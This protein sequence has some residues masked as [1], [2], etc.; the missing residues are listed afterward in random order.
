MSKEKD[1]EIDISYKDQKIVDVQME[2]EVK[3]SFIEYAMSVIMSRALPDVRDGLK[4]VHRRILYAMHEDHLT[5]DKPYRKSATTVGNVL[6]SYHPHGDA[7]VYDAM[8]RLA[9]PFSLR[10]TLVDGQGN[11]GN[12]DGDQ[13][14][15]YRY[16]EARMSKLAEY[17]LS[18][19]EK[20]VVDFMPNFDN[21]KEEPTVLPARYPNL[22]VNGCVG[23]AV[24]MATNVP[25][26]NMNEV[27]DGTIFLM[28]NPDATIPQIMEYIKGPDFPTGAIICGTSGIYAAYMT[29]KGKITVRG[30]ATVEEDKRR[31][32]ITEI[33]Y[34]VNKA[35]LVESMAQCVHDKKI[36]GITGLRDESGKGGLRIVVEYRRD[37]NGEVILNQLYKY[38]QLQDTCAVNMLTLVDNIPKTLN[39]KEILQYYI[40]H[41]VDVITRRTKYELEKVL[42]EMHIYE[43]YKI[44]IDNIDEVI[45]IIRASES[46]SAARDALMVRFSLSEAQAQAIVDMT[47]GKLSGMERIKIEERLL[48]LAERVTELQA[49]LADE[50][51]VHSIIK[52]ELIEIK[53]KF[54]DERR[55]ELAPAEEEI[56]I[57]D[58][59][60]RHTCVVTMSHTG[61]IKRLNSDTYQAQKRG[62]KGI[63]GMT[64]KDEDFVEHVIAVDS[65]SMLMMFTNRGKVQMLKAYRIP[66]ASRT[67]KGSNIVNILDLQEGEKVTAFIS[68]ADFDME[69]GKDEYLLFVT[70]KGVVK[71]TLLSEFE[72]RRKGGKIAINLDEDDELVYVRHTTG[73]DNIIIATKNGTAVRFDENDARVMSRAARGVRGIRLEDGDRVAGAVLV[74]D[75][76]KLLTITE[77]GYG[78]RSE[79]DE[80]ACHNRGGKGV[81]CHNITEKTGLLCTIAGVD[82]GMD[83]M[84]ITDDGTI[85]RT[86]V[87]GIPTY[88][89]SAGGVIVM[90]TADGSKIVNIAC[91]EN[92]DKGNEGGQTIDEMLEKGEEDLSVLEEFG[93]DDGTEDLEALDGE[94]EIE[95][96]IE[97]EE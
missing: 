12:I 88:S 66:E 43:G 38:T 15:A 70:A 78:K 55:T 33:P 68:I 20:N 69:D 19:I 42:A 47:L 89:R 73:S 35:M 9:Q 93:D 29:G 53:N 67:A 7:A 1:K 81:R 52:N 21:K 97:D 51:K 23:I 74:E 56:L 5:Y 16:T 79:F 3:K 18:D 82:E 49:I 59:I 31:I 94:S 22:L 58:L 71:R 60:D 30:R 37:A 91:V 17:M 84:M 83:I 26:H 24:G 54:G 92:S 14:A 6:G 10:Y 75:G 28:E 34:M 44:A 62:G 57:E 95:E 32:I 63:V 80:F 11:F 61:Y 13:A 50:G 36:E 8:V 2:K 48:K 46:V 86:P 27:I 25:T 41:Q 4:P 76:K 90:R 64:T 87:S 85:I 40:N 96:D 72:Y 45:E 77:N 65:H 39:L